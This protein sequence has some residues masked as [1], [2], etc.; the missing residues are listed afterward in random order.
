MS[1][2][3]LIGSILRLC[4]SSLDSLILDNRK[5]YKDPYILT[6]RITDL[7]SHFSSLR[8]LSAGVSARFK[9]FLL[10]DAIV[11]DE[12][13]Y[14]DLFLSDGCPAIIDFFETRGLV[15]SLETSICGV[16]VVVHPPLKFL[17][18]NTQITKLALTSPISSTIL[19]KEVLPLLSGPFT[20]LSSLYLVF[21]GVSIPGSAVETI[22]SIK[23]QK[24]LYLSLGD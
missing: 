1:T 8:R 2:S 16:N 24:H 17:G 14:L 22:S 4:S 5:G 3:P 23:A 7:I 19:E 12:L 9:D 18:A 10:L 21:K 6:E 15:P 13:R 20:N 11:V